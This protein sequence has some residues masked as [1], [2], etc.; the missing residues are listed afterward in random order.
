MLL[1]LLDGLFIWVYPFVFTLLHYILVSDQYATCYS[2]SNN[3][4]FNVVKQGIYSIIHIISYYYIF[5]FNIS[6]S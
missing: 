5:C 3:D 6:E 4:K 2:S 1:F